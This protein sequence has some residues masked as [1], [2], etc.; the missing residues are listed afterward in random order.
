[1]RGKKDRLH[2]DRC[3][4]TV[5]QNENLK[6]RQM[7][8][9][10]E[11]EKSNVKTKN[12]KC[13]NRYQIGYVLKQSF[14]LFKFAWLAS[15]NIHVFFHFGTCSVHFL[16][17]FSLRNIT[18][19]FWPLLMTQEEEE[20]SNSNEMKNKIKRIECSVHVIVVAFCACRYDY[21]F[22]THTLTVF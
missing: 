2:L 20:E 8:K 13:L 5:N 19:C 10:K 3:K 16:Y 15:R 1:M 18:V 12:S 22:P 6:T 21:K 9:G 17:R 4:G 7:K 14:G 11:R